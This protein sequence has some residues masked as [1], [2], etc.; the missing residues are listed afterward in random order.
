MDFHSLFPLRQVPVLALHLSTMMQ[1]ERS[2]GHPSNP[3]QSNIFFTLVQA[4]YLLVAAVLSL[5]VTLTELCAR[6]NILADS[7]NEF[8]AL[9]NANLL[10][11]PQQRNLDA[12]TVE[13][14]Q[15]KSFTFAVSQ[16]IGRLTVVSNLQKS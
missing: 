3:S 4:L 11:Q 2:Q 13:N 14:S 16:A 15:G 7:L 9:H 10:Q 1:N 6:L 5:V 12:T 8:L